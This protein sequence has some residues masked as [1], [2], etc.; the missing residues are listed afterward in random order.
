MTVKPDPEM[1]VAVAAVVRALLK[2]PKHH[3]PSIRQ[4]CVDEQ[5]S[6]TR[7]A[8]AVQHLEEKGLV[9]C[10]SNT[11]RLTDSGRSTYS[12]NA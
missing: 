4:Q 3:L 5:I 6:P 2:A 9:T 7:F 11:I 12:P 8:L 1:G 10:D